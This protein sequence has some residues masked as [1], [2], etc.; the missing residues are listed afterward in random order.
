MLFKKK[1][2]IH[3]YRFKKQ[4][5]DATESRKV[6]MDLHERASKVS[7][8]SGIMPIFVLIFYISALVAIIPYQDLMNITV[9]EN[10]K[11]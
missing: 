7:W 10:L 11:V 8:P 5:K 2:E 3:S 9:L 4:L 1:N 6:L